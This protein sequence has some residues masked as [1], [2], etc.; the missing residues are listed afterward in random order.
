MFGYV[1]LRSH[2]LVKAFWKVTE[3]SLTWALSEGN[4]E[5]LPPLTGRGSKALVTRFPGKTR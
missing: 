1:T 5:N 2:P 3:K 4:S